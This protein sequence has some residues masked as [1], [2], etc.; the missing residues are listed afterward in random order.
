MPVFA[1]GIAFFTHFVV[2][3]V[4][5]YTPRWPRYVLAAMFVVIAVN[6]GIVIRERPLVYMEGTKNIESRRQYD[7]EVPPVL[8]ALAARHPGAP[9]LMN[10]SVHPEFVAFSGITLRQTINESDREYLQAALAAPARQAAIVV[11]F[12]GDDV[13][14]AV[15]AHPEGLRPVAHFAMRYQPPGTIYVSDT[16][17]LP[18]DAAAPAQ[19]P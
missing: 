15:H 11:A 12:E 8:R 2:T 7:L 19:W 1:L 16:Y 17:A 6:A 10:T 18:A 3:G 4:R 9:V 5:E 13:D 14:R